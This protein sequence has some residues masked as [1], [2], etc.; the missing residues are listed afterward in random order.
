MEESKTKAYDKKTCGA[1]TR[2]GTPCKQPAG[3]GTNHAGEGRCKLHGGK[4]TG[5]KDRKK[6]S[7]SQKKNNN[8]EKHGLFSK[9]LP[10]ETMSLVNSMEDLNTIDI[11][12]DNIKVQYAAI[13]RSQK[14]MYVDNKEDDDIHAIKKRT[15]EAGGE[16]AIATDVE[17][18]VITAGEKQANF[19][20]S[21]SRAMTT[22]SKM[23]KDYEELCKSDLA[24]EQQ[25]L[26]IEKLKKEVGDSE[27]KPI[28]IRLVTKDDKDGGS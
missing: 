28:A 21:Q 9:Y 1:K 10:E 3:W 26:R 7:R 15:F 6:Q 2:A 24:T 18:Q 4:S 13:I 11:L 22:L 16:D 5:P 12:W 20:Q 23:I 14:I 25:K 27:D 19:L 8:A 17:L